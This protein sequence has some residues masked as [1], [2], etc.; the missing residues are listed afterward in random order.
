MAI[1]H[2]KGV[3]GARHSEYTPTQ[4][5]AVRMAKPKKEGLAKLPKVNKSNPVLI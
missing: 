2:F 3:S 4:A 1:H 5:K